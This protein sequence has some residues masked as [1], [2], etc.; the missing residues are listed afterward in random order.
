MVTVQTTL[1]KMVEA[2]ATFEVAEKLGHLTIKNLYNCNY[3]I[4]NYCF[5]DVTGHTI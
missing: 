2:K 5:I 4:W 1:A 3:Y